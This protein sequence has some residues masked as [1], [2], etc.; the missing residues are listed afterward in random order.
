MDEETASNV[1]LGLETK[2][3]SDEVDSSEI[4]PAPAPTA[5]DLQNSSVDVS[6]SQPQRSQFESLLEVHEP[7]NDDRIESRPTDLQL[8]QGTVVVRGEVLPDKTLGYSDN[9]GSQSPA[10]RTLELPPVLDLSQSQ[11][12]YQCVLPLDTGC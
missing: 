12:E 8:D 3:T 11:G 5:E 6:S 4:R 1:K 2:G 10:T 7:S 9:V